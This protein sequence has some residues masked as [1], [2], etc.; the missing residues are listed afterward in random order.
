MHV[1]LLS[2]LLLNLRALWCSS[3]GVMGQETNKLLQTLLW[4]EIC[5]CSSISRIAK[6][7]SQAGLLGG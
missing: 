6:P 1:S 5:N 2:C 7:Q 3:T 4:P